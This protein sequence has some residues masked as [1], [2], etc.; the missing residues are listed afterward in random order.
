MADEKRP[1]ATADICD[2]LGD[3]ARVVEIAFLDFG[4]RQ[5]FSGEIVTVQAFED[6]SKLKELV[7]TPGRGRVIVF[8]GVGSRRCA[9][10]GDNVAGA[11]VRNGWAGIVIHG[12]VRDAAE[13]RA[14]PIGIKA[15]GTNPRKS[16]KS[17]HGEIGA[18]LHFGSVH[19]NPGEMLYADADGVIVTV[20]RPVRG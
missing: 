16:R 14:M 20:E 8:D 13:L 5:A 17:G 4:G 6:N 11:A 18:P 15:I 9:L 3:R 1:V 10:L 19:F 2:L 7:E 12:C